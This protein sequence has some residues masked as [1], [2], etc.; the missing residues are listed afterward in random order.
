M[1]EQ[2]SARGVG[3]SSPDCV[4]PDARPPFLPISGGRAMQRIPCRRS[5]G[6]STGMASMS[7]PSTPLLAE[8]TWNVESNTP[9]QPAIVPLSCNAGSSRDTRHLGGGSILPTKC[10]SE[11]FQTLRTIQIPDILVHPSPDVSSLLIKQPIVSLKPP[12]TEP[13]T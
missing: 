3:A 5:S 13:R 2:A 9:R 8:K 12:K 4:A 6:R 7:G 11:T 1:H 10:Y